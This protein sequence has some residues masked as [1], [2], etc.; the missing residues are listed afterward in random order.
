MLKVNN[1]SISKSN[2]FLFKKLVFKLHAHDIL[3]ISGKNGSGKTS[4]LKVLAEI[5]SSK[6]GDH[7]S[8][9]LK[10]IF[11]PTSG[12][13]REELNALQTTRFFLNCNKDFALDVLNEAGLREKIY[14]P[15]SNLSEGQKKRLMII[16]IKHSSFHLLLLDEPFNTLDKSAKKN[17]AE[18]LS[19]FRKSGG[20]ILIATHT[21]IKIALKDSDL[22]QETYYNCLPS[23]GLELDESFHN[24]WKIKNYIKNLDSTRSR[25]LP[26]NEVVRAKYI[27][28]SNTEKTTQ[29]SIFKNHLKREISLLLSKPADFIWPLVFMCM[30]VTIIP[31]GVGY[32]DSILKNIASGILF[33]SIFLVMTVTCGQLFETEKNCGAI[34]QIVT[35]DNSLTTYCTVKSLLFWIVVGLPLSLISIPLATIYGMEIYPVIIL[36]LSMSI[37]SLSLA[38]MLTLFSSLALMARQAQIIIGLLAFPSIVPILI[39]GTASVRTFTDGQSPTNLIFVLLGMSVFTLLVFPKICA[40]L[41]EISLD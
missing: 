39:F 26:N 1:L 33:T 14:V 12:G 30:L 32:D 19:L 16:R 4:L 28:N 6:E 7:N 27:K 5:S 2:Q 34:E 10:K 3:E 17:F 22:N 25:A 18:M 21:P 35:I 36:V 38:M 23:Y 37:A 9:N 11:I 41:L 13:M 29:N 24:G 40:T 20:I 8:S 31:F 15:I